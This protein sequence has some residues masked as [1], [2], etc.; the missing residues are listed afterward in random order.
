MRMVC[1]LVMSSLAMSLD[2]CLMNL[3][4]LSLGPV[5]VHLIM[6]TNS[7]HALN[8]VIMCTCC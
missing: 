1:S 5:I 4:W 3:D 2:L 6:N 8:D 7:Q